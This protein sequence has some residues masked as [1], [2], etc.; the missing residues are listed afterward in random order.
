VFADR[1]E[2]KKPELVIS[3]N[4]AKELDSVEQE[5]AEI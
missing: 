3:L 2:E 1:E 4:L 5:I